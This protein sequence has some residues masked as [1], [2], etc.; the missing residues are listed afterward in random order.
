MDS[1]CHYFARKP[2]QEPVPEYNLSKA[3]ITH[4]EINESIATVRKTRLFVSLNRSN[5]TEMLQ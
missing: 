2:E 3:A 5:C 1:G 4:N